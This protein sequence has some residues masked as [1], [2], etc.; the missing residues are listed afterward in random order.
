MMFYNFN[1]LL[2][3]VLLITILIII[4]PINAYTQDNPQNLNDLNIP[5]LKD[6]NDK[7]VPD[8]YMLES[9]HKEG[10][11]LGGNPFEQSFEKYEGGA[12]PKEKELKDRMLTA[13]IYFKLDKKLKNEFLGIYVS[14]T[15]Y[16]Y[17]IYL[18]GN[19]IHKE[20]QHREVYHNNIFRASATL[21]PYGQLKYGKEINEIAIQIYSHSQHPLKI[22]EISSYANVRRDVFIRNLFYVHLIQ[23]ASVVAFVLFLF[24]LFSFIRRKFSDWRYL[25]FAL[26]C[27]FYIFSYSNMTIS[28]DSA[29][30]FFLEKL[31]RSSFSLTVLFLTLF[32]VDLTK[33]LNKKRWVQIILSVVALI[34]TFVILIQPTKFDVSRIFNMI[35]NF[36]IA[37]MLIFG[38]VLLIYSIVKSRKRKKVIIALVSYV[39]VVVSSIGDIIFIN[40]DMSPPVYLVNYGFLVLVIAIFFMLSEEQALIYFESKKRAEELDNKNE[41]LKKIIENIAIVSQNLINSSKKLEKNLNFTIS[42]AKNYDES[43]KAILNNILN[44]FD[45]VEDVINRIKQR[46][47]TSNERIPKA[48]ENQTSIVEET[49][50]S[51]N[52]MDNYIES[53]RYSIETTNKTAQ[54]LSTMASKSSSIVT[55]SKNSILKLSEH[56][57]FIND[58]LVTIEDITEQTNLLAMNASIE[59]ARAGK[60]GKGFSVVAG[61]I[62]NLSSQ[63]KISLD[64]SKNK[65]TEMY[66]IINRSGELSDDVSISLFK[67]IKESKNSAKMIDTITNQIKEEKAEFSAMLEAVNS[68]LKDTLSIKE[69]S[70]EEQIENEKV[71]DILLELKNSFLTITDLLKKQSDKG[72]ELQKSIEIIREVMTENLKNVD[73]LN[74]NIINLEDNENQNE[75]DNNNSTKK[76]LL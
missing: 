17:H 59:A 10:A 48:I 23:A 8:I 18:N 4:L 14:P 29:P 51:I 49:T 76:F 2:W 15:N 6:K 46:I 28:F 9:E 21:L 61:E 62:R 35:T 11:Y 45:E 24:F 31:S 63:S 67:I 26:T 69:M 20:G 19:L 42:I 25:F 3:K 37:P 30:E 40:L 33:I 70:D 60:A 44:E 64:S 72:S 74:K 7:I 39:V 32:V 73:I 22:D 55:K 36:I 47:E 65:I 66:E 43:N 27:F 52:N 75:N 57:K 68:L 16:P 12:T 54:H 1:K 56:S 5:V 53:I 38:I 41:S 13:K 34:G 71:K 50:A 58:V